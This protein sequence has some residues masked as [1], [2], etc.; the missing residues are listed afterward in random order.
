MKICIIGAGW[1]GCHV[2]QYLLSK[3][4]EIRILDKET[5]IFAGASSKNQNRLHLGYHYP[6]SEE[7]IRECQI[8]FNRFIEHYGAF[9]HEFNKNYYLIHDRSKTSLND[10]IKRFNPT[11]VD[12]DLEMNN[13]V[14]NAL[15]VNER[16]ID[17]EGVK[18][19]FERRLLPFFETVNNIDLIVGDKTVIV[20]G[21]QYDAIIN[22]TNNQWVPIPLPFTPVYETFCSFVYEIDFEETTAYTVMDGAF[23][24]IFPYDI[25][26]RLYTLTHVNYGVI[27][28]SEQ[29][30]D[31]DTSIIKSRKNAIESD[32]FNCMP[33]L[34]SKMK[35]VSYFL[36][37]KTKYDF[38]KDDRSIRT[39]RSGR[40][41]SF[42][43]GK[44]TGIFETEK[45]LDELLSEI[46]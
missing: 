3:G 29:I 6:R 36:S 35:Y 16:H 33:F 21:I 43:G 2:A 13:I 18:H 4:T 9:V 11:L 30:E 23:F 26:K 5:T 34:R 32:V 27:S 7:T 10:Y 39:F 17:N 37:Q 14:K 41:L 31:P 20:N 28:R 12:L 15:I 22:C 40:Y 46:Q 42:S 19:M 44:I 1:Y 38:E 25:P 24:S 8:G 45:Y